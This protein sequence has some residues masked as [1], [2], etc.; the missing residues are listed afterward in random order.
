[1]G[2]VFVNEGELCLG[3]RAFLSILGRLFLDGWRVI[4]KLESK[5]LVRLLSWGEDF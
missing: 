1:M 3:I 2:E 4:A 5:S